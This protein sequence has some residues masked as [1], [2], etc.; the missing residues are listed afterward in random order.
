MLEPLLKRF[1]PDEYAASIFD[2]DYESLYNRGVRGLIFDI[3]N[4]IE[5]Y[6]SPVPSENAC[7]L[8]KSLADKGFSCC[9]ASNNAETRVARFNERLGVPALHKAGKPGKAAVSKARA[10]LGLSDCGE[11]GF[12]V[13]GDQV[14]TDVWMGRRSGVY[15]VLVKPVTGY[16]PWNVALKRLAEGLVLRAYHKKCLK[17]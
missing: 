8:F 7:A 15:T 12:A 3:D 4:T 6:G 16:D 10:M 1:W 17:K 13:I 9:L 5:G 14:F 11:N 2:I